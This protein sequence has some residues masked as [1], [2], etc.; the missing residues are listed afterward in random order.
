[1]QIT[2]NVADGATP[3]QIAESLYMQANL[4]AGLDPKTAA[5][6]GK[7]AQTTRANQGTDNSDF[8]SGEETSSS[9]D[10]GN[11]DDFGSSE[12]ADENAQEA[13][14][15]NGDDFFNDDESEKEEKK[16]PAKKAATKVKKITSKEVN[17]ACQAKAVSIGGKKGREQ[18]LA[19]LKKHFGT[20]SISKIPEDKYAK[21]LE[22]M[23]AGK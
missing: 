12:S 1:M 17:D 14:T 23:K 6:G 15:E 8:G 20:A 19:A 22:V 18:V 11:A 5:K 9:E 10:S 3:K 16:A 13:S 2:I 21:V 4:F 7:V